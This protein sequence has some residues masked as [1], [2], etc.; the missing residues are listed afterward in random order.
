MYLEYTI[1]I[2]FQKKIWMEC[3]FGE[4]KEGERLP[5]CA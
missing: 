2:R 5:A 3:L 1:F 4:L